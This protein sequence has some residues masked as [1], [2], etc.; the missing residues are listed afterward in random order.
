MVRVCC[1][2]CRDRHRDRTPGTLA[3]VQFRDVEGDT[4]V[5]AA[6][7][8]VRRQPWDTG[9]A[10]FA[11]VDGFAQLECSS[12]GHRP[13]SHRDQLEQLATAELGRHGDRVYL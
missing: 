13:R 1:R 3:V 4:V 9:R 7:R 11:R 6:R 8:N 10:G 12:C 2:A 5:A